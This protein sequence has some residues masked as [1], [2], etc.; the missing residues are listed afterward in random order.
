MIHTLSLYV[1]CEGITLPDGTVFGRETKEAFRL[2][3]ESGMPGFLVYEVY[4]KQVVNVFGDGVRVGWKEM[5]KAIDER[6]AYQIRIGNK[7][8]NGMKEITEL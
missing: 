6:I 5:K 4:G 1:K 7:V 8:L 2:V 3:D